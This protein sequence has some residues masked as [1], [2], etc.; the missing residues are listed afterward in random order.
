MKKII[1]SVL[2]L[3]CYSCKNG[4]N[5]HTNDTIN[6]KTSADTTIPPNGITEGS[7]T[8]NDTAAMRAINPGNN[9]N[10]DTSR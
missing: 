7:V 5:D 3:A 2:F 6:A 9:K 8:S 4:N 10:K 1:I